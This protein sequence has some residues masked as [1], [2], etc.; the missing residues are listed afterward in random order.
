MN[1]PAAQQL[2]PAK[3]RWQSR[4]ATYLRPVAVEHPALGEL[5]ELGDAVPWSEFPVFSYWELEAG[6]ES[7]RAKPQAAVVASFANGKPA[8][9]ERQIGPGRVLM[10]TTPVS[11]PAHGEP[12]NLL[13]TGSDPW[14]FLALANGIAEYLAGVGQS[15]LNYM[16]GQ[17]VVLPLAPEERVTNYVLQMPD[18]SAVRQPL[19]PG[20]QDLTLATTEALGNYRVRAGGRQERL[21]RG[22]S[23][24]LPAELTRLDR[25]DGAEFISAL[26]KERARVAR[27]REEIE[28]RV[29]LA[30]TGRELFPIVILA[31][32][33]VLAAEQWLA[34]RFYVGAA[35]RAAH[36]RG[37]DKERGR[38]GE[39]DRSIRLPLSPSPPLP[40]SA[41]QP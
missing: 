22:F 25:V 18:G 24:N 1:A 28:V 5:R 14:P 33:L 15:H 36:P 8:L 7:G 2:L 21:D 12:W 17:T 20:Q 16:A 32:A 40:V 11:D 9:V 31:V 27:T 4:E 10:L 29:G 37:G 23:V 30:R 41:G 35:S 38:Q 3:L 26:G 39:N 19:T 34:N 6:A 13:P